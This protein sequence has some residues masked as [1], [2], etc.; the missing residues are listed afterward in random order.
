M[1]NSST[2][3]LCFDIVEQLILESLQTSYF[4]LCDQYRQ[5]GTGI[6]VFGKSREKPIGNKIE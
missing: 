2:F 5:L 1:H 4:K 3:C 6:V